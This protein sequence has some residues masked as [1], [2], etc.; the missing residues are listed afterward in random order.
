MA[1]GR[2]ASWTSDSRLL[3][4]STNP[5]VAAWFATEDEGNSSDAEIAAHPGAFCSAFADRKDL[6]PPG[7]S[8]V[9]VDVSP[10]V[11]RITAQQGCFSLHRDPLTPWL[12]STALYDVCDFF[13][14]RRGK[15]RFSQALAYIR[16]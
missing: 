13:G 11:A 4:W 9:I 6:G 5:M 12:P 14:S 10:R 15:G 1:R 16:L 7:S 3:D 8:P 2:P